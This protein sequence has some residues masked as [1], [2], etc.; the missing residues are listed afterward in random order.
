[1]AY[2]VKAGGR[3]GIRHFDF[4]MATAAEQRIALSRRL[5][6][7]VEKGAFDIVYQPQ[8]DARSERICGV[9]ALIRWTD[10]EIGPVSPA[11]FVPLAEEIGM[12]EQMG[13]WVLTRACADATPWMGALPGGR[14]SVTSR[15]A[16]SC[17]GDFCATVRDA[18]RNSGLVAHQLELEI[19]EGAL[20]VPGALP[21]LKTLSK[22]GVSIAIDDFGKGYSSL[23]YLRTFHADR[24]KIDMSFVRGIG[25]SA[26]DEAIVRAVLALAQSLGF[27]VVAEGVETADQLSF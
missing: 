8:I 23:S 20:V 14:I 9:E 15:L 6:D 16:N 19:T 7:A 17:L 26:T 5:R 11:I 13:R 18:L 2:Q 24:L 10:S 1:M 22:M 27:E 3:N 25:R 4:T 21:A 12:I